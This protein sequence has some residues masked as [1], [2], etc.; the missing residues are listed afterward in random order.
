M[1]SI[2]KASE[3]QSSNRFFA[4]A[5]IAGQDKNVGRPGHRNEVLVGGRPEIQWKSRELRDIFSLSINRMIEGG[6][7]Q[8][9]S[10]IAHTIALAKDILMAA[11]RKTRILMVW[12][13]FSGFKGQSNY[14]NGTKIGPEAF[15]FYLI[16]I[17]PIPGKVNNIVLS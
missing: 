12:K 10:G 9:S 13:L 7:R 16:H 2:P 1:F 11:A 15:N 5:F 8:F 6:N 17:I 4:I 14:I 3:P